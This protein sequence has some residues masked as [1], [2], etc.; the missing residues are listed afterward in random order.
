MASK[1]AVRNR[2]TVIMFVKAARICR[3]KT[4]LWPTLSHRQCLYL[5]K[6]AAQQLLQRLRKQKSYRVVLYTTDKSPGFYVPDRIPIKLQEGSNLGLR[7]HHAICEEL[8]TAN[9]VILVGS[10]CPDMTIKYIENAFSK[11]QSGRN[12][13]LGPANDGGYVL[14]GMNAPQPELFKNIAWGSS[15]VLQ[16]TVARANAAGLTSHSLPSLL[17][18]DCMQDLQTLADADRLPGWANSLVPDN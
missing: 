4:R 8:K 10:D 13:V 14:I 9:K 12:V 17:D 18:I 15:Q 7:M 1:H 3:V 2:D 11:L 6:E 16:Q 5:H